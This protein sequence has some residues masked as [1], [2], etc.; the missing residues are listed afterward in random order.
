MS[1]DNVVS[2]AGG[3]VLERAEPNEGLI[4]V[5]D[6]LLERARTG[7]LQGVTLAALYEDRSAT[8]LS[9]GLVGGH[10]MLGAMDCAHT[11]LRNDVLGSSDQ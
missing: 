1:S 9:A 2:I 5:L 3:P 11:S 8:W 10:A 4:L 7:H 6:L